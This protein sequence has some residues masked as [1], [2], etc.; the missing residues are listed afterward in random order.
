[1]NLRANQAYSI[2]ILAFILAIGIRLPNLNRPISKHH[3]FTTAVI[4]MSLDSWRQ[5]GGA[6][7]F[8]YTPV[9]N[10]QHP[11]DKILEPAVNIDS[12]GNAIY[13]SLGPGWYILPN[14]FYQAFHLPIEP[15]YLQWLNLL[16]H[17]VSLLLLFRFFT[18]LLPSP[19]P[20]RYSLAT[21]GCLFFLFTPGMLWY[22][23]NGYV[24]TTLLLPPLLL[25]L[26][27]LLPLFQSPGNISPGQLLQLGL[28][29]IILMYFDW[30]AP[31]IALVSVIALLAMTRRSAAYWKPAL[32]IGLATLLGIGLIFWQFASYAGT[33]KTLE[34]W[35]LRFLDRGVTNN[36]TGFLLRIGY[37]VAHHLSSY[38]PLLL[39]GGIGWCCAKLKRIKIGFTPV[40]RRFLLLYGVT[41]FL[42]N[43]IFLHWSFEHEF[44]VMPWSIWLA[45]VT[46]RYFAAAFPVRWRTAAFAGFLLLTTA[47][48]Y[49]INRPGRISRD[50]MAFNTF[51]VFGKELRGIPPDH[52]IFTNID[53]G[54]PM[55]EFYAG[56]NIRRMG[57][58]ED[59]LTYMRRWG[60]TK[61]VW[62]ENDQ[63]VVKSITPLLSGQE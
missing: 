40:E 42:Y 6:A 2:V 49:Y 34:Y 37:V 8:H 51:E 5:A 9:M 10:Y 48:Y 38:G 35:R 31:V 54:N 11:G 33:A 23:G 39:L 4:L 28:Y 25:F 46:T 44:S 62:V 56:R 26:T 55:I 15:I 19:D 58:K 50:G 53:K 45:W 17:G 36:D 52:T 30:L 61:A 20:R 27:T 57:K 41:C 14:L 18:R 13:L 63:F 60:I 59:A 29:L 7:H 21:A 32:T 16:V 43:L 22:T 3:D 12:A 1:M 47:Q 24:H